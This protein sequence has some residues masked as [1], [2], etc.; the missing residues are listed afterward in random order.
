M[1]KF[2]LPV[3]LLSELCSIVT[4][5]KKEIF[6]A[7]PFPE[8][9]HHFKRALKEKQT[10]KDILI[11]FLYGK[12]TNN[13]DYKLKDEDFEFLKSFPNI[14]IIYHKRLHAKFYANENVAL[15]TTLNLNHTSSNN[16]IEYGIKF[17]GDS[18][19]LSIQIKDFFNSIVTEG[20][21]IYQSPE[22]FGLPNPES[23]SNYNKRLDEIKSQYPNAYEKWTKED[24]EKLEILF[25]ER[26]TIKELSEIFQ[27]QPNAIVSRISKLE[28]TE[29]YGT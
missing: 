21:L 28:L 22:T 19:P 26:K 14:R 8:I 9:H 5:A 17:S 7:C 11:T 15:I 20:I 3:D 25:C 27:R 29:K 12:T 23:L 6:V 10:H 1:D 24:D 13:S 4:T 18:H 2:I 16:N